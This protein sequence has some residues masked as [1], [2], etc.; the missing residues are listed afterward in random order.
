MVYFFVY[1]W[2]TKALLL[3]YISIVT[4]RSFISPAVSSGL[5]E[6]RNEC[7]L[8]ALCDV[9]LCCGYYRTIEFNAISQVLIILRK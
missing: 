2:E 1:L 5:Q 6:R 3:K 8:I 7:R 4:Y 9:V